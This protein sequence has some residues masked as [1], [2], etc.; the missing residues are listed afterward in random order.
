MGNYFLAWGDLSETLFIIIFGSC[1]RDWAEDRL[2][3]GGEQ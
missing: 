2:C 1:G 3:I